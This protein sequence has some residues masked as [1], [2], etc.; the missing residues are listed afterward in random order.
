MYLSKPS[1]NHSNHSSDN[2]SPHSIIPITVQTISQFRQPTKH[3]CIHQSPHSIIQITVQT[4][5]V[6]IKSFKS[7]F[8]QP[9]HSS[10]NPTAKPIV[11]LNTPLVHFEHQSTPLPVSQSPFVQPQYPLPPLP[12]TYLHTFVCSGYN[13]SPLYPSA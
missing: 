3:K 1:F 10:D 11:V 8:R 7:Q 2:Q 4:I 6:I 9:P 13:H 12:Q 5:K